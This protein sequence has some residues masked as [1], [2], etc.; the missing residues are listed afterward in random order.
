MPPLG[1]L[2]TFSCSA[3]HV[4][5]RDL[6]GIIPVAAGI[7]LVTRPAAAAGQPSQSQS[8]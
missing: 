2:F 7:Y 8:S 5:F 4:E 3:R 6:L 1:M